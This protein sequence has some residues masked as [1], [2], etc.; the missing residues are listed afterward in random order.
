MA[1]GIYT[2]K[3]CRIRMASEVVTV[4]V[5]P[6]RSVVHC[7]FEMV[8]HGPATILEVGFLVMN[9][10][11]HSFEVYS[12]EDKDRFT[13]NV[14]DTVLTEKEIKVSKAMENVYATLMDAYTN[15]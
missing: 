14:N 1:N 8:N 5:Y 6:E 3:A 9:F 11:H 7:T 10:H 12:G 2:R 13:I 15:G 4:D